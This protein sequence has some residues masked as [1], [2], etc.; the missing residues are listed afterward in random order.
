MPELAHFSLGLSLLAALFYTRLFVILTT[1]Q[2]TLYT[3]HLELFLKLPDGIFNVS[4]NF[5]F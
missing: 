4:S 2:F 1:L 3:I 5:N